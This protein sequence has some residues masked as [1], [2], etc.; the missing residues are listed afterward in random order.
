MGWN[1]EPL[2]S[3]WLEGKSVGLARALSHGTCDSSVPTHQ[4]QSVPAG[5][6]IS[7]CLCQPCGI[8]LTKIWRPGSFQTKGHAWRPSEILFCLISDEWNMVTL[9]LFRF[10]RKESFYCRWYG[11]SISPS[12]CLKKLKELLGI[13]EILAVLMH[14]GLSALALLCVH[15]GSFT[16]VLFLLSPSHTRGVQGH[17]HIWPCPLQLEDGLSNP[18]SSPSRL[19]PHQLAQTQGKESGEEIDSSFLD[20]IL[21]G[22]NNCWMPCMAHTCCFI[23]TVLHKSIQTLK[24]VSLTFKNLHCNAAL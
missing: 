3:G 9:L 4:R 20:I 8:S 19:E 10:E 13:K 21:A 12:K 17:L 15:G 14:A 18:A 2:V 7:S 22:R 23:D 6:F 16:T 5:A 11:V 1:G 24:S